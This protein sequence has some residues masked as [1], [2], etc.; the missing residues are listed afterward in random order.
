MRGTDGRISRAG[1][2]TLVAIVVASA[3][4]GCA[5]IGS[6]HRLQPLPT[7]VRVDY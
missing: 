1:R 3:I 5:G 4:T 7:G 2:V 6:D